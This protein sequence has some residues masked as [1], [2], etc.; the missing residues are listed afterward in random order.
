[1]LNPAFSFSP[2]LLDLGIAMEALGCALLPKVLVP[3][4]FQHPSCLPPSSLDSSSARPLRGATF[5]SST[6]VAC[7]S[8]SQV[9]RTP[10]LFVAWA[11]C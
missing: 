4:S 2:H 10:F 1:M 3:A 6:G 7:P 8:C 9:L 11:P 5:P